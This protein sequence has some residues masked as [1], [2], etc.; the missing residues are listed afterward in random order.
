MRAG[1][2]DACPEP[3]TVCVDECVDTAHDARHCGGCDDACDPGMVC[4]DGACALSC[5][6]GQTICSELCVDT[7]VDTANCGSCDS[8]CDPGE[9]CNGSGECALSC[10]A[11]LEECGGVCTDTDSSQNHCGACDAPCDAGE[12]CDGSGQ[13]ALS[14]Q[15]GLIDCGGTCIDPLTNNAFCGAAGDCQASPGETCGP[16][17][18]CDGTGFCALT[19]QPG[20]I[21]CGGTCVDPA[22]DDA[23]CG[24]EGDCQANPGEV[25]APGF[26]CNGAG[27]CDLSCQNGLIECGGTCVDPL[28]DN[29]Y[30]GASG[31]C[32]ANDGTT[33]A[34][35]FKCN[36]AGV[37]ALSCQAG[38]I[39]CAGNCIDP[40]VSR[41]FC[42]ATAGCVGYD[43]CSFAE[44]CVSGSCQPLEVEETAGC[45]TNQRLWVTRP[46]SAQA[47]GTRLETH[48]ITGHANGDITLVGNVTGTV[49][50]NGGSPQAFTIVGTSGD[51]FLLQLDGNGTPLWGVRV[52]GANDNQISDVFALPDGAM[53]VT[54]FINGT[55]TFNPGT[56]NEI[57][58]TT[59]TNN[60]D[61][62][63]ARVEPNGTFSWVRKSEGLG[64]DFGEHVRV[65]ADGKIAVTGRFQS[66]PL[67]FGAGEPNETQ[68]I[69]SLPDHEVFLAV[70]E[71]DGSI[72]WAIS[73]SGPG[74]NETAGAPEWLSDG[75]LAITG[76]FNNS[77]TFSS[78]TG[79]GGTL[80]GGTERRMFVAR[81][82]DD[83]TFLWA[84]VPSGQ[85]LGYSVDQAPDGSIAVYT[86]GEV[87]VL[88]GVGEPGQTAA[89]ATAEHLARYDS[90][91]QLISLQYLGFASE[92]QVMV[93]APNGSVVHTGFFIVNATFADESGTPTTFTAVNS[94]DGYV[95]CADVGGQTYWAR[96]AGGNQQDRPNAAAV[97]PNG[98]VVV[99]GYFWDSITF[100]PGTGEA[101]TLTESSFSDTFVARYRP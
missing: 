65:R 82:A 3:F 32:Q 17:F 8:P 63:V 21:D 84:R 92:P 14:C 13:C 42:G 11:G 85:S 37:C 41:P 67:T 2:P 100:D 69:S 80:V 47:M 101:Q 68:L 88:F 51:G 48:G 99:A 89:T 4:G 33:C 1:S 58:L 61:S 78:T 26:N 5:P 6:T 50:F 7:D 23:F 31:A 22:T 64:Y 87:G 34:A 72:D 9:I 60:Y 49:T 36:G 81:Y 76:G 29:A 95:A 66:S 53:I 90:N 70:Y 62:F 10:Q 75:S 38:L 94:N 45:A 35:G 12:I 71:P 40:S 73:A 54:G 83:G 86:L 27:V 24:A 74:G 28:T 59:P 18:T 91:G 30:C 93:I 25:C 52:A 44:A 97:M 43:S 15:A 98:D 46:S 79:A 96:H 56:A 16:G 19:C 39:Q 57:T 55:T 77:F 20:L